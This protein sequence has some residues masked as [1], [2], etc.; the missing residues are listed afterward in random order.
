M[1][2][3]VRKKFRLRGGLAFGRAG[4]TLPEVIVA[5][6]LLLIALVPILKALAQINMNSVTIERRTKSLSLAKMKINQLQ[7]KSINNFD[8]DFSQSNLSLESSYLCNVANQSVNSNLK[9][10]TVSVGMDRNSSGT[11]DSG[12]IEISLQTQIARR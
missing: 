2:T 3:A 8:E 1:R 12:E 4:F 7:A 11:L 6:T 5:S 9:A 10:L